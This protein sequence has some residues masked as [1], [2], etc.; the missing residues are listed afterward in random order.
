[1]VGIEQDAEGSGGIDQAALIGI[2]SDTGVDASGAGAVNT[3]SLNVVG[4]EQEA[5]NKGGKG[6]AGIDQLAAI[7]IDSTLNVKASAAAAAKKARRGRG[8]G[9]GSSSP[10]VPEVNTGVANI[11]CIEQDAEIEAAKDR[12]GRARPAG[13]VVQTAAVDIASNVA[14]NVAAAARK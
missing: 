11:V 9:G 5:E 6:T 14:V 1:M 3:G 13:P 8:C 2:K 7:N 12:C 4:V 10:G